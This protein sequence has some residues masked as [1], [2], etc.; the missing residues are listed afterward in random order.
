MPERET[1]PEDGVNNA[2]PGLGTLSAPEEMSTSLGSQFLGGSLELTTPFQKRVP[3]IYVEGEGYLPLTH[4]GILPYLDPAVLENPESDPSVVMIPEGYLAERVVPVPTLASDSSR[5]INVSDNTVMT[6]PTRDNFEPI[7]ISA[8]SGWKEDTETH[9]IHYLEGD[10][11][12]R[13]AHSLAQ[14]PRA[15][16]WVERKQDDLLQTRE[17]TVYLEG[18]TRMPIYVESSPGSPDGTASKIYDQKWLGRFST[19]STIEMAVMNPS[20]PADRKPPIFQRALAALSPEHSVIREGQF[21]PTSTT[22][23][24]TGSVS[25]RY[26]RITLNPRRDNEMD[27]AYDPYPNDPSRGILVITKG[28]N[29]IIQGV[30]DE[31]LLGN[32]IDISAE[33]AVVWMS[34]PSKLGNNREHTE[35]SN[36]DFE[37]YLEGHII[38]R[39]QARRIEAHRMYYDARNNL[40]YILEGRLDTPIVGLKGI[41]GNLRLKADVLQQLGEGR[42]QAKNSLVTTSQLGQPT[43]SLRSRTLTMT[44][45]TSTSAFGHGEPVTQQILVAEN[46][47]LAAQNVPVFYWPWMAADLKDPTFYIKTLSYGNSQTYG[48]RIST[49]WNPF[50]LLNI[51]NRPH[52]LDGDLDVAWME[53]RGISHGI[54]ATYKPSNFCSIPGATNGSLRYWGLSDK[55]KDRLGGGRNNVSFPEKYRYE[56]SWKHRQELASLGPL[57]G[58]WTFD[59]QLG[60]VSDRNIINNFHA[61]AWKQDD[62][63]TTSAELKKHCGDSTLSLY[64]EYAL[65][66][67]YSNANW[68]PRLDHYVLGRSFLRDRL[69][70]YGHT[71]VGYVD[72]NTAEAPYDWNRDGRYFR[73]MP[74]ELKPGSSN[75]IPNPNAVNPEYPDTLNMS[76]ETFSTRHELDL[77]FSVGPVRF[78]PYVLGDFSHWGKDRTGKDVQRFY[79]QGG[80]RMN[81]PFW[82]VLPRCSSRTWYV[83]GLAHKIDFNGEL[84]YARSDQDLENLVMTDAMDN[85]AGEDARRRYISVPGNPFNGVLPRMFDP[86]YYAVR[87]GQ[88]GNVTASNME[89]VDDLTLCRFGIT[90]RWQT[91]RGPVGNRHIIDWI[92]LSTH[93]NYYPESE[94]NYGKSIGLIDYN[95]LWHVGDRFSLFSNGLYD[96]FEDGQKITRVGA[97]WNRPE[98]GSLGIMF[99]Q[100]DGIIQRNYLTLSASYQMNE[101]YSFSYT[102][103]LEVRSDKWV[104]SGHN[105]MFVRKGESFRLMI[106][107]NY[108]EAR[109][110]WGLSFGFEPVFMRGIASQMSSMSRTMQEKR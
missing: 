20:T 64:T 91:K 11:S 95:F 99:D 110:E 9:E 71:R 47:Y 75:A 53:K 55:G 39:D 17:V 4:P 105:F 58:P 29:I 5:T 32:E 106:G 73:Y 100:L 41:D 27:I 76:F 103:S 31:R 1:A 109:D 93:F 70:W 88:G 101:K 18:E 50:Q 90:Q 97:M 15:V 28:L 63:Y 49:T 37:L 51:R 107:A 7:V 102:T 92:T 3:A 96:L 68:L 56:F 84:S 6:V 94:Q 60:K 104:N 87:T 30:Q 62:N 45:R 80:V 108:N 44:E 8:N 23:I 33:N 46:N 12:V 2:L 48:N 25:P 67:F 19:L 40:A 52:W 35:E 82:K 16:V 77:P 81:I 38:F 72:Y 66:D 65:D 13:Q 43:Y 78:V 79:G 34:N 26:R 83:N 24:S 14:G 86:R 85:W 10:C 57:R 36:K 61:G 54:R 89:L 98:R 22:M 42:F 69:T 21:A 59:A 74:W